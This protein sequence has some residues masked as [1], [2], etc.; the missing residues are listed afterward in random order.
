MANFFLLDRGKRGI[1]RGE[2]NIFFKKLNLGS[3]YAG[4]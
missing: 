2:R 3:G 4:L 1:R